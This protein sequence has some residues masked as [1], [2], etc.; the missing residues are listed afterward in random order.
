V[1]AAANVSIEVTGD[2]LGTGGQRAGFIL[3]AS[4]LG[5]W[6]F[7]RTSARLIRSPRVTWW[8]GSVETKS[9][10]HIH[11]LVW[12][13]CLVLI[14]GFLSFAL[15]PGSPWLEIL[16]A[17]FG[18]GTGLTLDEF[19]LWLHLEDVY[20]SDEGRQS[21]DA[22]VVATVFG[23]LIV[24]GV[25]PLDIGDTGS[26]VAIATAVG[27]DVLVCAVCALKGKMFLTL[28]GLFIPLLAIVGAVRLAT[29][30]SPWARRRYRADS[31]KLARAQARYSRVQGR[32]HRLFNLIAGAPSQPDP[33]PAPEPQVEP[34]A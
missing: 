27:L 9:G 20:W 33:P 1:R 15:Q 24:I 18:V 23:A 7:I 11:H 31:R 26:T 10:L 3:L 32:R 22:V 17:M 14:A 5:A 6:L 34:K 13:I 19:A 8:P 29:P 4:F 16:A 2:F 25:A 30:H 28:A 21:V 12:G